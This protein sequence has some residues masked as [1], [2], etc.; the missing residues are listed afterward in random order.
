MLRFFSLYILMFILIS[1]YSQALIDT[2]GLYRDSQGNLFSGVICEFHSNS[3]IHMSVELAE[4]KPDGFTKIYFDNGQIE[5]VRGYKMG[6]MHGKWEKWNR[7]NIKIAEAGYFENNK[8]GK[9]LIWDDNGT[10]R[11]DMKYDKGK[12]A[13][14]WLMFDEKGNLTDKRR[15]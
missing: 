4:G 3:A 6:M 1:G 9:W 15:Y 11:Y 12:K 10:L 13:G 8:N 2:E 14:R 7:D 5:E